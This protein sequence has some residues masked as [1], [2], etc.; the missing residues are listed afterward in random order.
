M[1]ESKSLADKLKSAPTATSL[2]GLLTL[3][4]NGSGNMQTAPLTKELS[5]GASLVS[6]QGVWLIVVYSKTDLTKVN[7]SIALRNSTRVVLHQIFKSNL[8]LISNQYG[9]VALALDTDVQDPVYVA[10]RLSLGS[11]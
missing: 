8:N 3:F 7:L 6:D 1:S 2:S 4:V 9:T 10:I 5:E 11:V